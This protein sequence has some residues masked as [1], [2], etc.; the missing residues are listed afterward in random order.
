MILETKAPVEFLTS[1][2]YVAFTPEWSEHISGSYNLMNSLHVSNSHYDLTLK[3][4]ILFGFKSSPIA[5]YTT[6][7]LTAILLTAED[8]C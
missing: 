6:D 8:G 1:R 5:K 4:T 7:T 2:I 3:V